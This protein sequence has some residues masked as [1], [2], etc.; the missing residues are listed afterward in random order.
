MEGISGR[1]HDAEP[2][3]E[4]LAAQLNWLR[5]GVLGANDGIVSVAAVL[6][7]VATATGSLAAIVIAGLAAVV[8]GS[9]SMALGEY[10]SV[11]SARDQQLALIA[12]EKAEL[13]ADPAAELEELVGLYEAQGLSTATAR[14][15][16]EELTAQDALGAHLEAELNID[17]D[18]IASPWHAALASATA[19]LAG[20]ALPS[21]A[22]I[23]AAPQVRVA[24]TVIA[25]MIGLALTGA[26]AAK[27]GGASVPRGT[28]R[29]VVGGG[30]AL[31]A[32]FAIGSLLNVSGL[33]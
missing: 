10:V 29:V 19:F 11:S 16:A 9:V 32:T 27:L 28:V 17:A 4:G 30:L 1:G 33:V 23:V 3:A 20:A 26:T 5:A 6:V 12:K 8:G 15:V 7:G 31:A 14:L 13:A 2:H 22:V 18:D 24:V 25:T 21:V